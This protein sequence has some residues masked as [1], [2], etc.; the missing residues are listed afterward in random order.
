ME[1]GLDPGLTLR[2]LRSR[3]VSFRCGGWGQGCVWKPEEWLPFSELGL[4]KDGGK[5]KVRALYW[6]AGPGTQ[7]GG[8]RAAR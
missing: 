1:G 5:A 7:D 4:P 2:A 3:W 6:G 8:G